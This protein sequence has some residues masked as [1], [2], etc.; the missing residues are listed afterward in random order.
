V[1]REPPSHLRRVAL[2][3]VDVCFGVGL[4]S[5]TVD[6]AF[7]RE[8]VVLFQSSV[9]PK[10]VSI[11][12]DRLLLGAKIVPVL[13]NTVT[14]ANLLQQVRRDRFR[15][16]HIKR[17]HSCRAPLTRCP[18]PL[19]LYSSRSTVSTVSYARALRVNWVGGICN[20]HSPTLGLESF[21]WIPS[22]SL[23]GAQW[24]KRIRCDN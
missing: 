19:R 12:S 5:V 7:D 22:R 23:R 21:S 24:V 13:C 6:N 14:P 3:S 16:T 2:A 9:R 18:C 15:P 11:D 10:A 4:F 20:Q 8:C 17:N 1:R